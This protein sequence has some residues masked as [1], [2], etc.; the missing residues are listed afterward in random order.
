MYYIFGMK[1]SFAELIQ[2]IL[3]VWR[4][5]NWLITAI[6]SICC[7]PTS[8]RKDAQQTIQVWFFVTSCAIQRC[9]DLLFRGR[10]T[11]PQR[12]H[13][14][15]GDPIEILVRGGLCWWF[16]NGYGWCSTFNCSLCPNHLVC[17]LGSEWGSFLSIHWHQDGNI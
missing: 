11:N 1:S 8:F 10:L 2:L 9:L 17:L 16:F 12:S 5:D 13:C 3:S 14:C 4:R 6:I 15:V 7:A